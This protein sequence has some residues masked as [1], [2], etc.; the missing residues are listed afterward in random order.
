MS[1]DVVLPPDQYQSFRASSFRSTW[2]SACFEFFVC[3]KGKWFQQLRN[4]IV[5]S[6]YFQEFSCPS[7]I[8]ISLEIGLENTFFAVDFLVMYILCF[9]TDWSNHVLTNLLQ[10]FIKWTF[11]NVLLCL[12]II[13]NSIIYLVIKQFSI[14]FCKYLPHQLAFFSGIYHISLSNIFLVFSLNIRP[15][16]VNSIFLNYFQDSNLISKFNTN[17]SLLFFFFLQIIILFL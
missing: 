14:Y 13:N 6:D 15:S 8:G 3:W 9:L 1:F 4:Q 2:L 12:A 5:N 16:K 17:Y 7:T 10:F 11:R